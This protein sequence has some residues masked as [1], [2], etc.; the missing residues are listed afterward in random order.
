[1]HGVRKVVTATWIG[2]RGHRARWADDRLGARLGLRSKR[3]EERWE[4]V[5]HC[6]QKT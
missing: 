3:E 6:E 2:G 4:R 5:Q 1:M